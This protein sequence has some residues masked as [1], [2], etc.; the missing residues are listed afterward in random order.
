MK[1]ADRQL[2]PNPH[3]QTHAS[4]LTYEIVVVD[5]GSTDGTCAV[6][7]GY[8]RRWGSERVRLLRLGRNRGKGGALREVCGWVGGFGLL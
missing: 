8:S 2:T 5:D 3:K 4:A 7:K 6:V 1:R